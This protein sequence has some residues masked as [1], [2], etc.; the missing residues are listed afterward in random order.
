MRHIDIVLRFVRIC[1]DCPDSQGR[2]RHVGELASVGL[3][4]TCGGRLSI[5]RMPFFVSRLAGRP[6]LR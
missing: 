6:V 4:A 3:R 2:D 5:V 1:G